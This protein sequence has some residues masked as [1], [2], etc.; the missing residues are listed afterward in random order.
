MGNRRD[1][2]LLGGPV[3]DCPFWP[4]DGQ[5]HA[6]VDKWAEWSKLNVALNF[7]APVFWR[8]VRTAPSAHDPAAIAAAVSKLDRFLRIAEAQLLRN[9]FLAGDCFTLADVQ[10]GHVLYRFHDIPI[11]RQDRPALHRYYETL[12]TRSAFREHVMVSYEDLRVTD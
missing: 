9:A 7:T 11:T 3:W 8:V 12:A 1:L 6:Q 10:F 4:R 5:A 2:A